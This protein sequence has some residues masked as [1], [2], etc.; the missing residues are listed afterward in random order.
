MHANLAPTPRNDEPPKATTKK[1]DLEKKTKKFQ[2]HLYLTRKRS[3][4]GTLS[5]LN[6]AYTSCIHALSTPGSPRPAGA[7]AKGEAPTP[8]VGAAA[9]GVPNGDGAAAAGAP[10][11]D[12][13][14]A[15]GAGAPKALGVLEA[16]LVAAALKLNGD[17]A[18][19]AGAGAGCCPKGDCA[20]D[21]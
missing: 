17:G 5:G 15:A 21:D 9:A 18:G 13:A 3:I 8:G 11:G 14:G 4:F 10:K 6:L 19:A 12:G 7:A 20:A 2:T 16:L 1:N